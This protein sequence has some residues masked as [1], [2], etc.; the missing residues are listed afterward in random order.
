MNANAWILQWERAVQ[1]RHGQSSRLQIMVRLLTYGCQS[2]ADEL[3]RPYKL[4]LNRKYAKRLSRLSGI[5][6]K[7]SS[8]R[9]YIYFD[10]GQGSRPLIIKKSKSANTVNL[11]LWVVLRLPFSLKQEIDP[12]LGLKKAYGRTSALK[13]SSMKFA[14][15]S[16]SIWLDLATPLSIRAVNAKMLLEIP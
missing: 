16:S 4:Q 14:S 11:Q 2:P 3:K 7:V 5:S 8:A 13:A 6:L 1:H 9:C 12:L 10:C 15:P